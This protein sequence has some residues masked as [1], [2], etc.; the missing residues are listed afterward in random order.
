MDNYMVIDKLVK[1]MLNEQQIC[2]EINYAI[3]QEM[4]QFELKEKFGRLYY[5][6]NDTGNQ[7]ISIMYVIFKPIE[8]CWYIKFSWTNPTYRNKGYHKRLKVEFESWVKNHSQHK[9]I[10]TE[11]SSTNDLMISL[12][13]KGG[14]KIKKSIMYKNMND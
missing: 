9:L 5:I 13:Q 4:I 12:N 2:S 3:Y 14:Y 8:P 6:L 7:L 1:E 11:V 10:K